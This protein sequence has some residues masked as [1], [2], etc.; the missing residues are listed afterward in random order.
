MAYIVEWMATDNPAD[1]FRLAPE[2]IYSW[3]G[4]PHY[5]PLVCEWP[6]SKDRPRSDSTAQLCA[7]HG[8]KA[9][10]LSYF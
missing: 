5:A 2:I 3:D 4:W 1:Q 6:E 9:P 8:G 7:R 10:T